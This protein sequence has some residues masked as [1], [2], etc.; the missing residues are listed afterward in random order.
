VPDWKPSVNQC[1]SDLHTNREQYEELVAELCTHLDD[2]FEELRSQG[3]TEAHAFKVCL[4]DVDALHDQRRIVLRAKREETLMNSRTKTLWLPGLVSLATA[5]L[6]LMLVEYF[7]FF[8]SWSR[9][10]HQVTYAYVVWLLLLPL[11]GAA[12]AILSRNSNGTRWALLTSGLFPSLVMLG[13]FLLILPLDIL[14]NRNAYVVSHPQA[15]L[16][17][18]SMWVLAPGVALLVGIAPFFKVEKEPSIQI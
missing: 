16:Q 4:Q 8:R 7:T 2:R 9:V 6:S 15:F 11:C 12:G 10:S 18:A 13:A 5:S 17:A 14:I 3:M 1:L